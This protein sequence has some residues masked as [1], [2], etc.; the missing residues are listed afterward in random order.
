MLSIRHVVLALAAATFIAASAA[1]ATPP[2]LKLALSQH[3]LTYGKDWAIAKFL[4]AVQNLRAPDVH[5][6]SGQPSV[7]LMSRRC[8]CSR[9]WLRR[10]SHR[11]HN[12]RSHQHHY[13]AHRRLQLQ[14]HPPL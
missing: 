2:G 6:N 12:L 5:G 13:D 11:Q 7:F 8:A 3:C 4:P 1:Q 9:V 14:R 10:V